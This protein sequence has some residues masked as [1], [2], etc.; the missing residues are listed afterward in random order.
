MSIIVERIEDK[1]KWP[2]ERL[3]DEAIKEGVEYI[4][5]LKDIKKEGKK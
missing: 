3:R 1:I 2:F 4:K 5:K